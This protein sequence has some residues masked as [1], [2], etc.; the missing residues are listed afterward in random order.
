V[1]FPGGLD[2]DAAGGGKDKGAAVKPAAPASYL[3]RLR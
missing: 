3:G 2:K 1:M